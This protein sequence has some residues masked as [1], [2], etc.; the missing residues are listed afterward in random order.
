MFNINQNGIIVM[1]RGDTWESN[2]FVNLGTKV[3]PLPYVLTENDYLYFGVM[4]AN[5]PFDC[6]LIRKKIDMSACADSS[7]RPAGYY[8]ISFNHDDTSHVMPGNYYY[9]VKLLR[10]NPENG[11]E[12]VDTI[13][14]RTKFVILE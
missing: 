2:I 13:I 3:N 1:T 9:E 4:E 14:P 5:V 8:K 7:E 10:K 6:S 12:K 11:V